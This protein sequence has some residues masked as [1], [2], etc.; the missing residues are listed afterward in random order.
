M[1]DNIVRFDWAMKRLLRD[2]ANF[3]VL[4]GFLTSLL[5]R[6][7]KIDKILES[8]SNRDAEDTKQNRVDIL[9]ESTDGEKMLIE[10]Q[11]ETEDAYFQRILFGTSRLISDYLRRGE[12]YGKVIKVYSINIVYFRLGDGE[13]YVYHGTTEFRGIHNGEP[14]ELPPRLKDKFKVGGISEIY[15]EYYILRAKDFDKWS[16]TPLDQWMYFLSHSTIPEDASAP[17]LKEARERL[18]RASLPIEEQR[19]YGAYMDNLIGLRHVVD[20]AIDKGRWEG[21]ME[22]R[23][24]GI[25]I[26]REEGILMGERKMKEDMARKLIE[27]GF[28]TDTIVS[29]TG[30]HPN[31]L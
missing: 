18:K 6:Q 5:G 7:I 23:I 8:E 16:R 22:G 31:D 9:A 21:R 10:V 3:A 17:G 28:D 1:D 11:N 25:E 29:L 24:E 26:G 19:A 2:K 27:K 4:E 14:L 20:D 13:D 12:E 15:P 30:I